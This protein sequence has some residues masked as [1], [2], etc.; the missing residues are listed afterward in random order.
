M[1]RLGKRKVKKASCPSE[2]KKSSWPG[3]LLP[4]EL[5][6]W[7]VLF[8]Q[9]EKSAECDASTV[10]AK[11][12]TSSLAPPRMPPLC[13]PAGCLMV[14]ASILLTRVQS[15]PGISSRKFEGSHFF[16]LA[17]SLLRAIFLPGP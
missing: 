2:L 1:L 10:A 12:V 3:F 14:I 11:V 9:L 8:I 17:A 7:E 6:L 16:C 5:G 4:V 13:A 15:T